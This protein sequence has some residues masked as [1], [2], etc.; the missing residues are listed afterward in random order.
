MD[1]NWM[2]R[3]LE[4][5]ILLLLDIYTPC[6]DLKLRAT[7]GYTQEMYLEAL[8]QCKI[9]L[10]IFFPLNHAIPLK[11]S[12]IRTSGRR[13]HKAWRSECMASPPGC[14][15]RSRCTIARLVMRINLGTLLIARS[16]YST[17]SA[18]GPPP[19][20]VTIVQQP[21]LLYGVGTRRKRTV[22]SVY[23]AVATG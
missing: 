9:P 2:V 21:N 20:H 14:T 12:N 19:G 16:L 4:Q 11:Q 23:P 18:Q 17:V 6:K 3:L 10:S 15:K 13:Y 22:W 7:I 5:A 8:E 1:I